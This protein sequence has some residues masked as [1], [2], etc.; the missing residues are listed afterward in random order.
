MSG[1]HIWGIKLV[2][3]H[4]LLGYRETPSFW[5]NE[6]IAAT[7]LVSE[8]ELAEDLDSGSERDEEGHVPENL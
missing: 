8:D 6:S 2:V 5:I 7:L 3:H 1:Q 4:G